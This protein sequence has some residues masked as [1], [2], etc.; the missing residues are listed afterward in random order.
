MNRARRPPRISPRKYGPYPGGLGFLLFW[1]F[2]ARGLTIHVC[3]GIGHF[4]A[5]GTLL[6]QKMFRNAQG[7]GFVLFGL[8]HEP[9]VQMFRGAGRFGKND[10]EHAGG[11]GFGGDNREIPFLGNVKNAHSG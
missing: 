7:L 6:D 11:A 10:R 2:S 3:H 4:R 8:G 9:A 1:L 5:H